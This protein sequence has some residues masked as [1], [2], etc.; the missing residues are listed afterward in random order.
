MLSHEGEI[1]P[2]KEHVVIVSYQPFSVPMSAHEIQLIGPV[3]QLGGE[4]P[5]E[6]PSFLCQRCSL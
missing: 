4:G 1:R 6:T 3:A 5:R 2:E